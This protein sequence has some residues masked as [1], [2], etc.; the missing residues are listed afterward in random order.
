MGLGPAHTR[1][2]NS[3]LVQIGGRARP[4]VRWTFKRP[5]SIPH[6]KVLGPRICH[7]GITPTAEGHCI[8]DEAI[9]S[10]G[11]SRDGKS[12]TELLETISAD[13]KKEWLTRYFRP[14][15]PESWNKD[16]DE[17]LDNHSIE[18][19]LKQYQESDQTFVS[20]GAVPIDFAAPDPY[21]KNTAKCLIP[22]FCKLNLEEL[23]TQGK[24]G[25]G[26]VFN[27][28]PHFKDGS[29]WVAL[30]VDVGSAEQRQ[31]AGLR[32]SAVTKEDDAPACYYF[33]SYGYQPPR[34]IK[35]LMQSIWKQDNRC[36]LAYNGRRFQYSNTECGV[37]SIY[38]IVCMHYGVKFK[39]FVKHRVKDNV[40]LFLRS[41]F[42]NVP[43]TPVE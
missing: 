1:R 43:Q 2:H 18:A 26:M 29:H 30:Y 6:D 24:K 36:K 27:I 34:Q 21:S 42:W 41:W 17:W 32:K 13:V 33:D 19:V 11:V 4:S 15:A 10:S 7:P 39:H 3:R 16:P 38:F 8:P 14:K 22:A 28:D 9:R 5:A 25:V 37:Y 20:L 35:L 23:R 31:V 40:M 12:D